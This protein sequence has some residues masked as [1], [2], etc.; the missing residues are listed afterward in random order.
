[1]NNEDAYFKELTSELKFAYL[2]QRQSLPLSVKISLS[3]RRIR[4]WYES[5]D[6]KVYISFSGGKDATVL[7]HLVRS[8]YPEV[9][10]VFVDT[11]LEWP[12]LREFVKTIDN[13]TWLTPKKNFVQVIKEYGYPVVSKEQA[14]FIQEYRDTKS[15]KLRITR[16]EGNRWGRGKISKKWLHL[17]KAPFKVSDKCCDIMKKRP[18][19]EYEK[20]TG[21][22]PYVGIRAHESAMRTQ[23][24]IR[25]GCNS[26]DTKHQ[27]S[28]PIIFWMEDDVW[29]YLRKFELPY[30]TIYDKGERQTGC[31]FCG[32]G[33]HMEESPNKFQRMKEHSPH[34]YDYCINKLGMGE[35]LDYI[36]VAY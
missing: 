5:H 31:V 25:Y 6:G 13:V 34:L 27:I 32:F 33:V 22:R 7:L 12:E 35:V 18:I 28:N 10:A 21:L 1:M 23:R 16:L 36:N 26:F 17:I 30:A 29:E 19:A 4:E 24:Y 20:Q 8:I 15:E 11:G 9:P 2:Q 3:L 14:S